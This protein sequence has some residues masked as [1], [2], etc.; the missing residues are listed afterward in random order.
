MTNAATRSAAPTKTAG[1][2]PIITASGQN[3][4]PAGGFRMTE[5]QAQPPLAATPDAVDRGQRPRVVGVDAGVRIAAGRL[6]DLSMRPDLAGAPAVPS[7]MTERPNGTHRT[8]AVRNPA[9]PV[10]RIRI[11]RSVRRLPGPDPRRGRP[12]RGHRPRVVRVVGV[13]LGR[14]ERSA[15]R[16]DGHDRDEDRELRLDQGGD[17]REDRRPLGL[18]APQLAEAEEQ[19]H[20]AER[21]DLAPERP[22]RT[23]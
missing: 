18:V 21:V 7:S 15:D 14:P 3:V 23:S 9:S 22:S 10:V 8:T 19:E 2:G 4:P 1:N 5:S 16:D 6:E 17:D 20:D 11:G 13:R 12:A